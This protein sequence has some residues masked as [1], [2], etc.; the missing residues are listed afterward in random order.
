ML[1]E[2]W[3]FEQ[4]DKC[5]FVEAGQHNGIRFC[6]L[7]MIDQEFNLQLGPAWRLLY[8]SIV[9]ATRRSEAGRTLRWCTLALQFLHAPLV[10]EF[11]FRLQL[12]PAWRLL[13]TREVPKL[14]A[15]YNHFLLLFEKSHPLYAGSHIRMYLYQW[16]IYQWAIDLY[17]WMDADQLMNLHR[18]TTCRRCYHADDQALNGP[19]HLIASTHLLPASY[20]HFTVIGHHVDEPLP[21][22]PSYLYAPER[23]LGGDMN[24]NADDD[25]RNDYDDL[26]ELVSDSSDDD[27][28]A[29][30]AP[31][32]MTFNQLG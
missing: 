25:D 27:D 7:N 9:N 20:H 21:I 30:L 2:E 19:G 17:Q 15:S 23:R 1:L 22:W 29:E 6:I 16:A 12:G 8:K 26:P 10:I 3:M 18:W 5:L 14:L 4:L 28:G 32:H 11:E 24:D 13:Y 31:L